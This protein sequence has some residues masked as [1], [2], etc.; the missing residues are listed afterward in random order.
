[1]PN[2]PK[3]DS[4]LKAAI[5]D[6]KGK[7]ILA[8]GAII[9]ATITAGWWSGWV[10]NPSKRLLVV[11]KDKSKLSENTLYRAKVS[12]NGEG[13]GVG[14]SDFTDKEGRVTFT[15]SDPKKELR[16]FV[17]REG[18]END[19]QRIV[20]ADINLFKEFLLNPAKKEISGQ[21]SPSSTPITLTKSQAVGKG[22]VSTYIATCRSL[23][24]SRK[25]EAALSQCNK[26]LKIDPANQE[27]IELKKQ[28]GNTIK[29]L[30]Q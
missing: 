11:V 2:K 27:A 3:E 20:P 15:L 30:S 21:P 14:Q 9:A 16:V 26:A 18:F 29:I 12:L 25:Y 4:T 8:M 5:I 28:I 6:N 22:A 1:M 17:E 24:S 23:F 7:V 10:P 13:A 19:D